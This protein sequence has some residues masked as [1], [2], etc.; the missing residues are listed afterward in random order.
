MGLAAGPLAAILAG[1]AGIAV[2]ATPGG[3]IALTTTVVEAAAGGAR[4]AY[5][6]APVGLLVLT[7]AGVAWFVTGRG[8]RPRRAPTWTG[9]ITPEPAFE[10]TATSYAKLIRLYF[11]PILRPARE[12]SVELHPGTP[13]PRTVRY[14][15]RVTHLLDER[16]YG[17]LHAAA[18][19]GS[20]LA[21]RLQTGSLQLYLA[22][23][24]AALL[25]LLLLAR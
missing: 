22:Y 9:G 24:V 4:A 15:G 2:G 6:A 13:F 5:A 10:Y 20:K 8:R 19:A 17:P 16:V 12:V 23:A 21:R 14:R 11:G 25:A 18:I 1:I 7:G 3:S